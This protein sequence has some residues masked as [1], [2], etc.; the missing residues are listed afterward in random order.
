MLQE[1]FGDPQ[2]L[3]STQ[4]DG[5]VKIP[6][7]E[8]DRPSSLRS[9]YDKIM[10]HLRGL[11]ALQVPPEQYQC[12]QNNSW[13]LAIFRPILA[14]GQSNLTLVGHFF[15]MFPINTYVEPIFT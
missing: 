2:H 12:T 3:S 14:N 7:C 10:V 11:E 4:M 13:P 15:C 1:R 9:V 6:I 5:L 8:C